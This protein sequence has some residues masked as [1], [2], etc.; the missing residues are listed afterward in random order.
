MLNYL[1]I[2]YDEEAGVYRIDGDFDAE[3]YREAIGAD[4]KRRKP[5][6][7]RQ[8]SAD[9]ILECL[10]TEWLRVSALQRRVYEETG[11]SKARFYVIWPEIK[12]G[13]RVDRNER[14]EYR[15]GV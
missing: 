6:L 2:L 8:Y 13:I 4:G 9:D 1:G 15:R 3:R 7:G 10:G 12:D 11:M 14:G 5:G